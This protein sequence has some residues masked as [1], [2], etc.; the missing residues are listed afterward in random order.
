MSMYRNSNPGTS[1]EDI[2]ALALERLMVGESLDEILAAAGAEAK[3]LQPL[4]AAATAVQDLRQTVIV[5]PAG[6]G[7]NRFLAQARQ[8]ASEDRSK[9]A[10][11]R[12]WERLGD[13]LRFPSVGL[14]T[15][16]SA[17]LALIVFMVGTAL[18]LG[19]PSAAA[20][21]DVLPGQWLYSLKR[22]G[23]EIYL[24]LPQSSQSRSA[25]FVEYEKRRQEE[26]RM[27][28]DRRLEANVSF[29]GW[30]ER[31]DAGEVVVNGIT[32]QIVDET[33]VQGDL[34][35]GA[36]VAVQVRSLR[37]GGL[38]AQRLV[39]QR[40]PESPVTT[41]SPTATPEPTATVTLLATATPVPTSTPVDTATAEPAPDPAAAATD[42]VVPS[43]TQEMPQLPGGDE[44]EDDQA[45]DKADNEADNESNDSG[46][47]GDTDNEAGGDSNDDGSGEDDEDVNS[48]E[49]DDSGSNSNDES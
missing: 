48:H 1:Q 16:V 36:Q 27:L 24:W 22:V 9:P 34:A 2:L 17:A 18:F 21:R 20:A 13:R 4:L 28:V 37:S 7:L 30:I 8:A 38:I 10:P 45:N 46:G 15:A 49:D 14:T 40:P 32:L 12:W 25:I 5:P 44:V 43:P 33:Q 6:A 19:A 39:V 42:I 35:I 11:R 3:W 31:L 26:V 23:E 29:Q 47:D 41:P